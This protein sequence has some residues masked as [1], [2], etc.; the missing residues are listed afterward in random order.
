[1]VLHFVIFRE[2]RKAAGKAVEG[3]ANEVLARILICHI[4]QSMKWLLAYF[5]VLCV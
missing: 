1:M 5:K 4:S 2:L 3:S